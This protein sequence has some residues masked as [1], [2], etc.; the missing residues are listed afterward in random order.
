MTRS[1]SLDDRPAPLVTPYFALLLA[2]QLGYGF[3]FSAFLLLPKYLA[4][5]HRASADVIGWVCGAALFAAVA[6]VPL[7]SWLL[8]RLSSGVLI[9]AGA[10]LG[11]G[12]SLAFAFLDRVGPAMFSLRL[13]QGISFVLVFSAGGALVTDL[14]PKQ[15]LGQALGLWGLAMLITNAIAPALLEPAADRH[16]WFLVFTVAAG[17]GLVA[18]VVGAV[19]IAKGRAPVAAVVRGGAPMFD[20]RR[21]A[22]F[23]VTALMG[24]GLGTMFTFV[25]PFALELGIDRVS[26]FFLGYTL[27]AGGARLGLGD[28]ADRFGR[29]RVSG[30]ALIVYAVSIFCTA[31]LS[32]ELLPVVGAGIGLAH[33]IVYPAL[34][35]LAVEDSTSPQRGAVMAYYNGAF[36]VGLAV[37]VTTFGEVARATGYPPVFVLSAA[38][39]LFGAAVLARLP[40]R[41]Q[42]P[43]AVPGA[44]AATAPESAE[45]KPAR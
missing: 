43:I 13:L 35:A 16:G 5:V 6:T 29:A 36:N 32:R 39:V 45:H 8:S 12:A 23:G 42:E 38:L 20:P 31:W 44:V 37:S 26:G 27:A 15:R 40:S 17:A 34:N 19:V 2:V 10:L 7:A 14:V 28:L 18:A 24:A 21:L 22:V 9:V 33:G 25:Q 41:V 11:S 1:P 4:T 3:V 30:V